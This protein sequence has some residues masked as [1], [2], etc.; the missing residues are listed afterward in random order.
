MQYDEGFMY[1]GTT[2]AIADNPQLAFKLPPPDDGV[3]F[4]SEWSF[5]GQRNGL[6]ELRGTFIGNV[7]GGIDKQNCT[8]NFITKDNWWGMNR[9]INSCQNIFWMRY[10]NHNIGEW[11]TK[12]FYSGNPR[13]PL[14]S[15]NKS[16]GEP[17]IGYSNASRN[18][19]DLGEAL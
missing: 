6:V 15:I 7:P 14:R 1:L 10:F 16:T 8:W 4:E 5:E 13:T 9:F 11:R 18:F 17:R 19:I 3:I 2:R 12:R